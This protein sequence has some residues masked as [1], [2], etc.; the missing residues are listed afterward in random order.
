MEGCKEIILY[1]Y[2]RR[3]ASLGTTV[4]L[5]QGKAADV[6][7]PQTPHVGSLVHRAALYEGEIF[8][9]GN[10]WGEFYSSFFFSVFIIH[11]LYSFDSFYLSFITI[12]PVPN[13]SCLNSN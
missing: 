4:K 1:K 10:T 8:W 12:S 2:I 5:L 3:R 11:T 13:T 9:R 6:Y 7:P